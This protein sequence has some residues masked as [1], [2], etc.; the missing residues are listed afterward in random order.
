MPLGLKSKFSLINFSTCLFFSS[1][2]SKNQHKLIKVLKHLWH[3]Q[4]ELNI[5][6]AIFDATTFFAKYLEAYAAD[7][8]TFV[9]SFP[10]NAPPP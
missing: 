6:L 1:S 9:G 4:A 7:L 2:L 10:E 5:C 3:K 8:S